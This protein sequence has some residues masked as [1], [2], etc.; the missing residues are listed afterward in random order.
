MTRSAAATTVTFVACTAALVWV[1]DS[2]WTTPSA[3]PEFI[4]TFAFG[5]WVGLCA[6]AAGVWAVAFVLGCQEMGAL[7]PDDPR[8]RKRYLGGGALAVA[9]LGV[10]TG[11]VMLRL[12]GTTGFEAPIAGWDVWQK[13]MPVAGVAAAGPWV[14]TTWWTHDS[15][16]DIKETLTTQPLTED[17]RGSAFHALRNTWPRVE[18]CTGAMTVILTAGVLATGALRVALVEGGAKDVPDEAQVVAYGLFFAVLVAVVVVPLLLAYRRRARQYL[19][20]HYPAT[21]PPTNTEEAAEVGELLYLS[22]GPFRDPWALL[23]ILA[24]AVTGVLAAY[25]PGVGN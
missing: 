5:T 21:D 17:E 13:A 8:E 14:L 25:L 6:V 3:D 12:G 7:L 23:G 15:L 10:A 19:Q 18:R 24:P 22:R 16:A 4:S 2:A 11:V 9:A 20:V 1:L